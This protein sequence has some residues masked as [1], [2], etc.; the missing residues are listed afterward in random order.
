MKQY[1][2]EITNKALAD[3]QELYDYI[4]YTLLSPENA[5]GQYN[6]IANEIL[7]LDVFPERFRI[8]DSEPEHTKEI[9]RMQVDHYSVFY[10]IKEDKVFVIDVI[11]SAC[12]I[13]Y[14]LKE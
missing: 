8:L 12:D 3:M 11:Y 6:R 7:K 14:R 1:T 9:R 2:V 5:E 4:A 10:A 13:C